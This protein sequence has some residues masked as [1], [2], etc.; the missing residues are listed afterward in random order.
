MKAA[1]KPSSSCQCWAQTAD[2]T[3][4][5]LPS[6]ALV[7]SRSGPDLNARSLFLSSGASGSSG[8][9]GA[10][11]CATLPSPGGADPPGPRYENHGLPTPRETGAPTLPVLQT[12]K[13]GTERNMPMATQSQSQDWGLQVR[14]GSSANS[15]VTRAYV[16]SRALCTR[17]LTWA[18]QEWG[19]LPPRGT[20]CALGTAHRPPRSQLRQSPQQLYE[21]G[22]LRH[23]EV[24]RLD[25]DHWAVQH[26]GGAIQTLTFLFQ[27]PR[28]S[29]PC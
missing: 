2:D 22:K 18:G 17:S 29:S 12:R 6:P 19:R 21:A 15:P 1:P 20:S 23:G 7:L 8:R 28:S 25:Q 3:E 24:G 5:L 4:W 16:P 13:R 9:D 27:I 10:H 14:S 26:R 11:E